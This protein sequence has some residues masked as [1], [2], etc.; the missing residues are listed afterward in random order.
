MPLRPYSAHALSFLLLLLIGPAS[1]A[2][3]SRSEWIDPGQA[4][5]ALWVKNPGSRAVALNAFYVRTLGF[6]G[7][8]EVAF[9]AGPR[10]IHFTVQGD[11][12]GRW[13]RLVPRD[14]RRIW[15]RAHDSLMLAGFECG[16]RL[17]A[18][19]GAKRAAEEYVLDLKAVDSR[20]DSAQVKVVQ[21]A[22]Q[23]R[24]PDGP[25]VADSGPEE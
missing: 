5:R 8:G 16:A 22:P 17:R 10:R 2:D 3:F 7:F 11:A 1:S 19:Q 15:V 6:Q 23:Y 9:N 14:R 25:G 13:A 24:I 12:R 21:M 20:G 4:G 18:G